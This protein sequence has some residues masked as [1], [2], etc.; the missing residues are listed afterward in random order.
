MP[1]DP[2][3]L[4]NAIRSLPALPDCFVSANDTIAINLLKAL[5]TLKISVPKDVRIIGFDNIAE[6]KNCTPPLTSVNVNKSLL[7]KKII[8]LLL[9]RIANPKQSNQIIHISSKLV[10][11]SST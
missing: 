9:D 3:T 4:A 1:H 5:K 7:G 8:S 10:I 2:E 11:R 6:S